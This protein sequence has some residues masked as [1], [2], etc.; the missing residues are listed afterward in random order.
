[1]PP[2]FLGG[3]R[4]VSKLDSVIHKQLTNLMNHQCPILIGAANSADKAMQ[5]FLADHQRH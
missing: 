1:M 2:V 5:R 4:A 3:S